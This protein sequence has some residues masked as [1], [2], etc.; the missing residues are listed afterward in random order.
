MIDKRK[1]AILLIVFIMGLTLAC[2]ISFGSEEIPLETAVAMTV[3]AVADE[4]PKETSIPTEQDQETE[5]QE[6]EDENE[7]DKGP[8]PT[9][10][11]TPVPCNWPDFQSET[12]P[13]G[14]QF[15]P[16]DTF[17]KTW[18]IKNKG[19]CTWNTS[20]KLV[21]VAG[22]KMGGPSSK[23]LSVNV[24]PGETADLSVNLTAPASE[25]TY[26][27]TWK[28]QAD[29]G[30][31]FGNY[32]VEIKVGEPEPDVL[33]AVSS[34]SFNGDQL[35]AGLGCPYEFNINAEIKVNAA[36][37]VKYHWLD[38]KGYTGPVKS[39]SFNSAGTKTVTLT[40]NYGSGSGVTTAVISL[41]IDDPNHQ[42]FDG[43]PIAVQ[44]LP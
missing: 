16:G 11:K 26:K 40:K 34:V 12:I 28:I 30:E 5:N 22:D 15:D 24:D 38:N 18:R 37:T 19:T 7:E 2:E 42:Q 6:E 33:F 17:T 14:T 4:Q 29:D 39:V 44:C 31:Q 41:Y 25:G 23:A 20:Y 13:D 8:T 32:W 3:A 21:F 43:W 35:K 10:S 27:G 36:G 1:T 9:P